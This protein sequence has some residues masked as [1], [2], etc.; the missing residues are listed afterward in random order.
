[1]KDPQKHIAVFLA[2]LA[3]VLAGGRA[4][5]EPPKR[6]GSLPLLHASQGKEALQEI[7][8]L[9]GKEISAKDGYM[10]HY[11]KDGAAAMLYLAQASSTAQ[12][13]RQLKQMSDLIQRGGSPFYHL[14][15][16]KQGEI[17]L[18]SA[19]GQGQIHYFY[20]RDSSV[21]WLAVDAPVAKQ[22][23]AALLDQPVAVRSNE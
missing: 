12:A 23:M 10:A 18:Y 3:F 14:K 4:G 7:N 2:A 6:L 9:H 1:M 22:A 8:R 20:Q 5:A 15:T 17:T 13:A 11:E 19:L 16:S 21:V